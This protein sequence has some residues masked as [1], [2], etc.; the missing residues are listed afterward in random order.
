[1][2][3]LILYFGC[4]NREEDYIYG[5]EIFD[6][7]SCGVYTA[8]FEAFSREDPKMKVYVQSILEH[9]EDMVKRILYQA[10][11]RIYICGSTAMSKEVLRVLTFHI[12]NSLN[13]SPSQAEDEV[14]RLQKA[15]RINMEA[16]N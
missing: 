11:G 5:D 3:K 16:W 14:D 15:K 13:L 6:Q 12:A 1:M 8:V 2:G 4:R 10:E 7:N 9:K